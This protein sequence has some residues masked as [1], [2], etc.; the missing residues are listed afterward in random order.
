MKVVKDATLLGCT[1]IL[2]LTILETVA[3]LTGHD[4]ALFLPVAAAIAGIGG[5][6]IG[7]MRAKEKVK[8]NEV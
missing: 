5:F 2:G 4:G 6:T 8:K 7:D 1:A 3:M